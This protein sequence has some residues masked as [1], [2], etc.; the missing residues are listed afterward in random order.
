MDELEK[1]KAAQHMQDYIHQHID[2]EIALEGICEAAGY[3][4]RHA[5]RIFKDVFKMTPFE[6]VRALRV[7]SAAQSIKDD[8]D[9]SILDVAMDAGFNSHEGFTKAFKARFFGVNPS[10]YRGHLPMKYMYFMPSPVL[11]SY[12]LRS[13]KEYLAMSESTRT[14]TVTIVEKSA[15]K[16]LLKRGIAARDYFALCAEIGCD[17]WEALEA[18]S[19]V[20]EVLDRVSFVKLPPHMIKPGT[21]VA[22]FALEISDDYNGVVPE[23]FEI[24]DLPNFTYMWF[25][26]APYEDEDWYGHAHAEM[27]RTIEGYKPELYGYEFARDEAPS[28]NYGASA[29]TGVREMLPVRRLQ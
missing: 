17:S 19:S 25:Q 14:A 13:S 11:H 20:N 7:T 2:E 16:L 15:R 6:Y 18:F 1:I 5:F 12:L 24:I 22:V 3:S 10:K 4:K 8:S 27:S 21:S 9:A 29:A 23:G 28:Y 26:G